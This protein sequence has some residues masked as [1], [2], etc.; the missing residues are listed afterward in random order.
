[1]RKA[2]T[3]FVLVAL[4]LG[5]VLVAPCQAASGALVDEVLRQIEEKYPGPVDRYLLIEGAIRG[6]LEA[7]GDPYSEY[8]DPE[9]YEQFL[10][11]TEGNYPGVGL[12]LEKV[13][14]SVVVVATIPGSP[15][16]KAGIKPQDVIVKVDGQDVT[17]LPL[18]AVVDL[19]RGE[20]GTSVELG[21][22]RGDREFFVRLV[23][24]V[25][26]IEPV[27][28]ELIQGNLGYIKLETFSSGAA[29]AFDRA[30]HDLREKGARGFIIDLRGNGGG[31]LESAVEIAGRLVPRGE[32]VV[33]IQQSGTE[34]KIINRHTPLGLPVV[35]LVDGGT[36]SASEIVAGAVQDHGTGALVGTRT[37]GKGT[38]QSV[39]PLAN[40]GYLKL[41]T[42][43]YL[44]PSGREIEGQGLIPDIEV[45]GEEEQIKRAISVL[46]EQVPPPG[47]GRTV[48]FGLDGSTFLVNGREV[49]WPAQP[50]ISAGT[51]L[52]PVRTLI[53]ELFGG[54][55]LYQGGRV[56]AAV[57]GH[58][59]TF[60]AGSRTAVVDGSEVRMPVPA[61]LTEG[62]FFVP[63]R[64]VSRVLGA[65][66]FFDRGRISILLGPGK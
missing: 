50:Y 8:Y 18:D 48:E 19:I 3:V 5:I 11:L 66:V 14:G 34:D 64:F 10:E 31:Y 62:T 43:R 61:E 44:T 29:S 17:G 52:V 22:R 12:R 15:A 13:G 20:P 55:V 25:I 27:E 9:E 39:L 24:E 54:H 28:A 38:I 26:H 33:R 63:L 58:S 40:G 56:T 42:A 37:F 6:M 46:R 23:R 47:A 4:M 51:V 41:T 2:I 1:M 21:L 60:L 49:A 36:A 65:E 7:L 45:E 30:V 59:L 57:P 35:I 16:E 32:I 53:E